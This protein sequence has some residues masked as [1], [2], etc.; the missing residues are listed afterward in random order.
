M[1]QSK[2]WGSQASPKLTGCN[3]YLIEIFMLTELYEKYKATH[4]QDLPAINP[5][6]FI[7]RKAELGLDLTVSEWDWLNQHQLTEAEAR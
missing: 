6:S 2:Y 4:Y 5:L 1:L 3:S 7:L